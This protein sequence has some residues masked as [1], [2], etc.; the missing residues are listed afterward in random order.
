M[1]VFLPELLQAKKEHEREKSL[2]AVV[3]LADR[4]Q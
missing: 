4:R 3:L 1:L 2:Q